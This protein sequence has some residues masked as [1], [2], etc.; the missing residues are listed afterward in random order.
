MKGLEIREKI[1]GKDSIDV[2]ASLNNIPS[3]YDDQ[4]KPDLIWPL[5]TILNV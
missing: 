3:V 1:K 5:K 4:G 2:A